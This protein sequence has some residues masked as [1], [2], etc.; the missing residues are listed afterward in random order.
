[1]CGRYVLTQAHAKS[2]LA[3]LGVHLEA[4]VDR[5]MPPSR[6]NIPPG[7]PGRG[8]GG[9]ERARTR[10]LLSLSARRKV[11]KRRTKEARSARHGASDGHPTRRPA[12]VEPAP[13]RRKRC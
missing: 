4:G 1:M 13:Y 2:L 9:G 3:Q 8:G 12:A 6:Y 5:R 11:A 10:P 7:G